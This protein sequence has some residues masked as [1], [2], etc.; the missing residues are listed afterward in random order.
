MSDI[1]PEL[2][3]DL[4][5]MRHASLAV[6]NQVQLVHVL[7]LDWMQMVWFICDSLYVSQILCIMT[8]FIPFI[9]CMCVNYMVCSV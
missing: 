4:G 6:C 9:L 5:Y 8:L 3:S 7:L 1:R 2:S